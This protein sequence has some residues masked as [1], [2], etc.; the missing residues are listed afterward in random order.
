ML[1]AALLAASLALTPAQSQKI[2]AALEQV[3]SADHI[4]GLSIGVARRGEVLLLRGYG[5][6][7]ADSVYRIGS[8]TKQFTAA[9]VLQQIERGTLSF[10]TVAHGV[11]VRELL[12]QTSGLPSFTSS[13]SGAVKAALRSEPLFEPGTQFEYSNTNYYVLGTLLESTAHVPF[14]SLLQTNIT[15]PLGLRNTSLAAPSDGFSY[16]GMSS[17]ARDLLAWLEALRSGRVVSDADFRAM[18]STQTLPSGERTH[19]GYGF[20]IRDW[21]GW[22][23]AEHPGYVDG[24]S[25]EDAIVID[26]GL[27]IDVL[28][29]ATNAYLLPITKTVVQLLEP[30][31]DTALVADFSHP[32]QNEN[33]T[34]THDVTE[35]VRELQHG[36]LDR[37]HLTPSLNRTLTQQQVLED[38][39]L[40][41]GLGELTLVEFIDRSMDNSVAFE[42]YRLSFGYKQFW[43]MLSYAPD[44]KINTLTIA[45][46]DD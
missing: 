16:A 8:L 19:Y 9:L 4:P 7:T 20:Y 13:G 42:K 34:V 28:A 11:T 26:D 27:E 25:A 17:N 38:E 3:M 31:R 22:K 32:A 23:V 36:G 41:E 37:S 45:P 39:H 10:D 5:N 29:N 43:M 1:A 40:L 46:D 24:Y 6:S 18:T 15:A 21:Y 14:A 44:G 12:A 33:P 2:D 35:L 30:A